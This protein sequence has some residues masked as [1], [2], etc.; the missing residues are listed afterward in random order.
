[1]NDR[2]NRRT[3]TDPDGRLRVRLGLG[4]EPTTQGAVF[5]QVF[6]F[7]VLLLISVMVLRTFAAEAYVVPTGSMA[8]T[9]LG[10]HHTVVCP[11]CAHPF[12]VGDDEVDRG[13]RPVCPNCGESRIDLEG[14]RACQGDRL[15]VQKYLYDFRSPDRWEVI[16]FLSPTE[17]DQPYVKRVVGLPGESIQIKRGDI[18]INGELARKPLEVQRAMRILIHDS[19]HRNPEE[20]VGHRWLGTVG[21]ASQFP[22]VR[23]GSL[24]KGETGWSRDPD[25]AF[26]LTRDEDGSSDRVDWLVYQHRSPGEISPGPILD[27]HA[28]N[29]AD[30]HPRNRVA[31]VMVEA[32]VQVEANAR[33]VHLAMRHGAD[34]FVVRIPTRLDS[35]PVQVWLNGSE[36]GQAPMHR[37]FGPDPESG[38]QALTEHTIEATLIDRR[39][40][41]VVDGELLFQPVDLEPPSGRPIRSRE[42]WARPLALGAEGNGIR[43]QRIR[44]YR[45]VYY[46]DRLA[47]SPV[48]AFAVSE[49]FALGDDEFF[50]LGD[51]SAE[52]NDSR[53]W[54]KGPVVRRHLL[55]GK[56]FLVHL[57]SQVV[58]LKVFGQ[59]AYWLPD[60]R[61]IRFIR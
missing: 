24:R 50:V 40:A 59:P 1:M 53:F 2:A 30:Y 29:G 23:T 47:S 49:P 20:T 52:S 22:K 36:V 27:F 28:Y 35:G 5:R 42:Q 15:L 57:P 18:Y 13:G 14:A 4:Q 45:D 58:P 48:K 37:R 16:V 6:E 26:V 54:A 43:L 60:L 19:S 46:T 51:N 8:P 17:P 39:F 9:L 3:S 10:I 12:H 11:G 34:R 31:D 56:P 21:T 38:P 25:A 44:I 55:L 7:L 32:Q 61:Q 41:L 33:A